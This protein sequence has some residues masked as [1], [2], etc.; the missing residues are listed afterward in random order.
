MEAGG[1]DVSWMVVYVGQGDL[2]PEGFA[3]GPRSRRWRSSQ[4]IHRLTEEIAPDRIELAL[5]SD[6]VRRIVASG[7]KVAMIGVEN[8]YSIGTDLSNIQKFQEMGARYMSLSHNGHSQLSDSNTGERDDTWLYHGLSDLGKQA[9]AEMN[10]VGHHGGPVP[11]V[12]GVEPPGHG[13]LPGAGHRQPL[14]GPGVNDVSR[15][16]SDEELD[17]APGERR[18]GADGGLRQLRELGQE[19]APTRRPCRRCARRSPARWASSSWTAAP[20][21]R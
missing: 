10:R 15:N 14:L 20:S 5:T 21:S 19:H 1:T 3:D 11:S 6:D 9:I 2:T 16:L 13:A 12:E 17:G 8:G 4:A 7:K 18:R